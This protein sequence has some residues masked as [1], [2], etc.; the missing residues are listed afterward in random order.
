MFHKTDVK[1]LLLDYATQNPK[2]RAVLL[3]GSRANKHIKPDILQDYDVQFIV[4]DIE[5]FKENDQWRYFFYEPFL[6]QLPDTM[7]L[8][9]ESN[10]DKVSFTYLMLFN[11]YIRIDLTLFPVEKL[12]SHFKKDSLTIVWLD[13]DQLFENTPPPNDSDYHIKKP[14]EREFQ[15]V[16][17][18]FWLASTNVA[19]GLCR[20]EIPYSK[21]MLETVCRPMFMRMLDWKIGSDHDFQI[22]TGK[23]GKHLKKILNKKQYK[24]FLQTYA[25][26]KVKENW[27]ALFAIMLFFEELQKEVGQK[28]EYDV[29]TYEIDQ[30]LLYI[31]ELMLL[32]S[33]SKKKRKKLTS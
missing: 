3:N 8:G 28:T 23:S 25:G 33:L 22:T 7:E 6:Q 20:K 31:D 17:N 21:D 5:G 16:A 9:S 12:A 26:Y 30:S 19:K 14:M 29:D 24:R 10:T 4:E 1:Q 15:E 13:K 11:N 18:E 32:F 27:K 2:I